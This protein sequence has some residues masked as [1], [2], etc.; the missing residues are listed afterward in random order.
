LDRIY[1]SG[2]GG[3]TQ[4][5]S[6]TLLVYFDLTVATAGNIKYT[7]R[8]HCQKWAFI[9]YKHSKPPAT[10]AYTGDPV[11]AYLGDMFTY[12]P[13]SVV[14]KVDFQP[15]F[16]PYAFNLAVNKYGITDNGNFTVDR[17]SV[18]SGGTPPALANGYKIFL[19]QPDTSLFR[20]SPVPASPTFK[21]ISGCPGFW[22]IGFE[23][24][25]TGDMQL[26][27]DLNGVLG[28]QPGTTDRILYAYDV[29][30]VYNTLFWDGRDGLGNI[31]SSGVNSNFY[32]TLLRG[33]TNVPLYDAE[34]NSNGLAVQGI[35]P[36]AMNARLYWCD[37]AISS[38]TNTACPAAPSG[39]E[40]SDNNITGKGIDNSVTG[41]VGPSHA[42]DGFG[43][44]L[45]V[46]APTGGGG[47]VTLTANLCDDFGNARTIN[48]WFWPAT[49]AVSNFNV[50]IPKSCAILP[51]KLL[52]FT[53]N[54]QGAAAGLHWVAADEAN[55]SRYV[56]EKSTNGINFMDISTAA[57]KTAQ[58]NDYYLSDDLQ[59]TISKNIYYRLRMV[60]ED[61]TFKYSNIE[62]LNLNNGLN[63][64]TAV[65][66][67][68]VTDK[69]TVSI[70]AAV[71][72]NAQL[73][74]INN[75][76]QVVYK[77]NEK[78]IKGDNYCTINN[79]QNLA[80]GIYTLQ[81]VTDTDVLSTKIYKF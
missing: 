26:L 67:N 42:W 70:N 66:P 81:I 28:Y 60:A 27:L 65:Y 79:L 15:L 2:D 53:V 73:I 20:N 5:V 6:A 74:L 24:Q 76:G 34:I 11:Y 46:P 31:V 78:L 72:S 35:L 64:K 14:C 69:V 39:T 71:L 18:Y 80:K 40:N 23:V 21:I 1:V 37:S 7:G 29:K 59:N 55:L 62:S 4:V 50:T 22:V 58:Q 8:V 49:S 12:T 25:T 13:D 51:V 43:A 54:K 45:T 52:S 38:A 30:P 68:P 61:G 47:S 36:Q 16:R 41:S 63:K 48:T 32:L 3:V 9:T 10:D 75:A 17:M 56:V 77:Q 33:R 19:N 57:V 44:N